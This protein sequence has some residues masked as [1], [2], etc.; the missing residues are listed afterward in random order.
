[1]DKNQELINRR[2]ASKIGGGK[3]RIEKQHSQGK[4][5]ARERLT[6]LLDE[7]SFFVSRSKI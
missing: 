6:L 4:L 5:T 1:M 7:G 2:E 3:I